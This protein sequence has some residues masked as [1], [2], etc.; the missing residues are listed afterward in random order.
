MTAVPGAKAVARPLLFTVAT[1]ILDEVQRACKV[2]SVV[3]PLAWVAVAVNCW[4]APMEMLG[5]AGVTSKRELDP[6]GGVKGKP[7]STLLSH[8]DS[9]NKNIIEVK[10][11][12]VFMNDF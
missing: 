10:N 3:V 6:V 2:T 9:N 4:V 8:D 7:N 11:W 5:L 12:R 1:E